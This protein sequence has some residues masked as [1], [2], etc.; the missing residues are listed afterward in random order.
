MTAR[1]SAPRCSLDN[2]PV[3]GILINEFYSLHNGLT[4]WI[5]PKPAPPED[6]IPDA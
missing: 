3:L 5:S 1:Q 2:F 4:G 6:G